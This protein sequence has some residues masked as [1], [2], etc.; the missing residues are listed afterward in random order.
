[1]YQ[2]TKEKAKEM[3]D[4]FKEEYVAFKESA[5]VQ[6]LFHAYDKSLQAFM[7]MYSKFDGAPKDGII[8]TTLSYHAYMNM[9]KKLRIY[10]D[11]VSA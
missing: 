1:M 4:R 10:P 9:G 8:A 7:D 3:K 5:A 6:Q 2:E 11:I